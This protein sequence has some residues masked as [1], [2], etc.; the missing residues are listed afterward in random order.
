MPH[1]KTTSPSQRST[2][3]EVLDPSE[4]LLQGSRRKSGEFSLE[5]DAESEL[6]QELESELD[7][8][9]VVQLKGQLL[10]MTAALSAAESLEKRAVADYANLVRRTQEDRLKMIK[11]AAKGVITALLEPLAHLDLASSQL[12]D[13]GLNMCVSQFHSALRDQGL[14]EIEAVGKKFDPAVMEAIDK[15]IVSDD[16]KVDMVIE[17]LRRGYTLCG[18]VIEQAKVKVGV[19]EK[20]N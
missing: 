14:D 2:V 5:S 4:V 6:N 15:E 11:L 12:K 20:Q 16:S 10:Q 19:K 7:S 8:P 1:S 3:D 18:E 17:V 13:K 9:E